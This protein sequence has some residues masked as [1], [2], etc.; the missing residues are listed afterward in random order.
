MLNGNKKIYL[1]SP[2][3]NEDAT[4]DRVQALALLETLV[5]HVWEAQNTSPMQEARCHQTGFTKLRQTHVKKSVYCE[6]AEQ[7]CRLY[8][9]KLLC[10]PAIK[11]RSRAVAFD[12]NMSSLSLPILK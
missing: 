1:I 5:K 7:T 8:S 12:I 11:Y 2:I 4:C 9:R 3:K 6:R 10:I